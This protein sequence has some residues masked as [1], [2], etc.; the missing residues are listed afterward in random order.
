MNVSKLTFTRE[1][2]EKMSKQLSHFEK[3]KLRWERL[4]ELDSS[5]ELDKARNRREISGMLGLGHNYGA[6]YSW[7]SNMISRGHVKETLL[8]FNKYNQ[9]EYEYSIISQ[10]VYKPYGNAHKTKNNKTKNNKIK[11]NKVAKVIVDKPSMKSL[12]EILLLK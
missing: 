8:G 5:G 4:K 7:I 3:G 2:K 12:K 9:P 6:G 11:T 1:T 10:P